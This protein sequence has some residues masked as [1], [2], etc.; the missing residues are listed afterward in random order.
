V[1]DGPGRLVGGVADLEGGDHVCAVYRSA[2]ELRA[3][4]ASSADAAVAAH[5]KPV[6]LDRH[7]AGVLYGDRHVTDPDGLVAEFGRLAD[8]AVAEGYSGLAVMVDATEVVLTA[9][10]RAAFARVEHLADRMIRS[11]GDITGLCVY[12][13]N[14]LGA[15]AVAELGVLHQQTLP[16]DTQFHLCAAPGGVRL[17]GEL[18]LTSLG[19]LDG[20]FTA[21]TSTMADE[22][23]VDVSD[24]EFVDHRSLL[25]LGRHAAAHGQH[26]ELRSSRPIVQRLVALS[27]V[28]HVT[29]TPSTN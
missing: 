16:D 14:E 22:V 11:R 21:V 23:V 7:S 1:F 2:D 15:D 12:D 8:D 17:D 13:A 29:A 20:A 6:F 19:L 24:L 18:D 27:G 4:V 5:R 10:S 9:A 26:V 3:I 25:V 28:E